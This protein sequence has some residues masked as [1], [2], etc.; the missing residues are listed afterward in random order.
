M[1]RV[2][3]YLRVSTEMQDLERQR[4]QVCNYCD[5]QG[6][7]LINVIEEKVS[8]AKINR[9][10]LNELLDF[11]NDDADLVVVSEQSRFSREKNIVKV[12]MNISSVLENGLD[13]VFLDNPNKIYKAGTEI[14]FS[15]LVMLMAGAYASNLERDKIAYRMQS[16][17]EALF[18]SHPYAYMRTSTMFGFDVIDNPDYIPNSK[19]NTKKQVKQLIQINNKEADLIRKIFDLYVNHNY[20]MKDIQVFLSDNGYNY[21]LKSIN[22]FLTNRLYIGERYYKDK[23][24]HTIDAIVDKDLFDKVPLTKKRNFIFKDNSVKTF[25]PF[26][27]LIKCKCGAAFMLYGKKND[28]K[29]MTCLNRVTDNADCSNDGFV[30]STLLTLGKCI[31]SGQTDN[32]KYNQETTHLLQRYNSL[33]D[34]LNNMINNIKADIKLNNNRINNINDLII[35]ETDKRLIAGYKSKLA[36][37]YNNDEHLKNLIRSKQDEL[38]KLQTTIT[39]L[40]S[41]TDNVQDIT[42]IELKRL[43]N[44]LVS[45]I[46]YYSYNNIKGVFKIVYLNGY[47]AH[48]I[49]QK[50]CKGD[51]NEYI[52]NVPDTFSFDPET[53]LFSIDVMNKQTEITFDMQ[54]MFETRYYNYD[55]LKNEFNLNEWLI[56]K[57]A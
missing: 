14:E 6:F 55:Q 43:L 5:E 30:F 23:L 57:T 38:T 8:G 18:Y 29:R 11:T 32:A 27:G 24:V 15:D 37:L 33:V 26:K 28:D 36:D 4:K 35:D 34:S 21:S 56:N 9:K 7:N 20:L 12:L 45:S 44:G 19:E 3:A 49:L 41:N 1:K 17:K 40:T 22:N 51:L 50:K 52:Y 46:T 10:G 53:M 25:N 42:D 2:I 54:G 48:Y 39:N 47:I 31:V 13:L 16:G